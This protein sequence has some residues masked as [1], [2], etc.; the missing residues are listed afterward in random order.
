MQSL[1]TTTNI[2]KLSAIP[3]PGI[4]PGLG[5]ISERWRELTSL[6]EKGQR[7]FHALKGP[8]FKLE[9]DLLLISRVELKKLLLVQAIF[10]AS[11]HPSQWL[12]RVGCLIGNSADMSGGSM[13]NRLTPLVKYINPGWEPTVF[14]DAVLKEF[15][16]VQAEGRYQPIGTFCIDHWEHRVSLHKMQLRKST[17][18]PARRFPNLVGEE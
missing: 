12:Q 13:R 8:Q 14:I 18:G 17:R 4:R 2:R 6:F 5:P 15:R 9:R 16:A 3:P 11:E 10:I 7:F 1:L